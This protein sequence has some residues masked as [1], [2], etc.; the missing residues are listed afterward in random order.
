V[1]LSE[2]LVPIDGS[3]FVVP[4]ER[5]FVAIGQSRLG[6]LLEKVPGIQAPGGLVQ[7]DEHGFTGRPGWYA[8][9][10]CVNGGKEVVN[11]AAEGKAAA[12][13]IHQHLSNS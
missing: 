11:A 7:V 5:V 1:R 3:D 8:G 12:R 6:D 9:G 10:D 13:A 2:D 4:A